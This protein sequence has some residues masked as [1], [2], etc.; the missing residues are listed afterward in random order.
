[1]PPQHIPLSDHKILFTPSLALPL[2]P[3]LGWARTLLAAVTEAMSASWL[4]STCMTLEQEFLDLK[5]LD[6][7]IHYW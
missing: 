1:M 2:L 5:V 7:L 4:L 3:F 6:S